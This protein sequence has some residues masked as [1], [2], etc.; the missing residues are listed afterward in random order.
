MTRPAKPSTTT[1]RWPCIFREQ[2]VRDQFDPQ[3]ARDWDRTYPGTHA[4]FGD[5]RNMWRR[6]HCRTLNPYGSESCPYAPVQC[7][8]AFYDSVKTVSQTHRSSPVGYLIKVAKTSAAIRADNKPLARDRMSDNEAS[9]AQAARPQGPSDSA[10]ADVRP[11]AGP[12][13]RGPEDRPV[14]IAD[15][16]RSLD[17]RPREG[18]AQ[19][20]RPHREAEGT[21]GTE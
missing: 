6:H 13:V 17:P 3:I 14:S 20:R 16:L 4:P 7:A 10:T 12:I 5:M 9:P 2:I 21:E 19:D 11:H 18:Q 8:R 15:V 1:K